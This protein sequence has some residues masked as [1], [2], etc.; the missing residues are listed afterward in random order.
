MFDKTPWSLWENVPC[1]GDNY[2]KNTTYFS[3]FS[4]AYNSVEKC[5]QTTGCLIIN[6]DR[7]EDGNQTY[8]RVQHGGPDGCQI[9]FMHKEP[10]RPPIDWSID[11]ANVIGA[12]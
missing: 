1:Y 12:K 2:G 8:L 5:W 11:F 7:D 4:E 10:V 6:G 3:S 9:R